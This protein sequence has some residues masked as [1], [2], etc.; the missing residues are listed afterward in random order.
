MPDML[1]KNTLISIIALLRKKAEDKGLKPV[2]SISK[3]SSLLQIGG[4]KV[5]YAQLKKMAKDPLI[6]S[7]IKSINKN[8]V[9]LRLDDSEEYESKDD[10]MNNMSNDMN[11]IPPL[12]SAD[13][14]ENENNDNENYHDFEDDDFDDEDNDDFNQENSRDDLAREENSWGE[15]I[16]QKMASRASKRRN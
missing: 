1:L 2:I 4:L 8:Q 16:V 12:P 9:E 10:S 7:Y 3:L 14:S 6:A 15:S 5:T 11:N 13:E